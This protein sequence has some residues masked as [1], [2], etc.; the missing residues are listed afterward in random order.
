M[1]SFDE[2]GPGGAGT[3]TCVPGHPPPTVL[4]WQAL[5]VS[6]TCTGGL[7]DVLWA[8]HEPDCV[9]GGPVTNRPV[10]PVAVYPLD[11]QEAPKAPEGPNGEPEQLLS[12]NIWM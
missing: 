4:L 8:M 6:A 3:H 5:A 11:R 2:Y 9:G 10:Q 1:H 7:F 12:G